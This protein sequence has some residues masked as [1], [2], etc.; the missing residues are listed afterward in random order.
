MRENFVISK[1]ENIFHN[2][3]LEVFDKTLINVV[4]NAILTFW[5]Q[6]ISIA[7][8]AINDFEELRQE[9]LV[10]NLNFFTTQMKQENNS[11]ITI[12][13]NDNFAQEFLGLALESRKENFKLNELTPLEI[14]ILNS[15]CEFLYK[16]LSEILIPLE[17]I[18]KTQENFDN[19]KYI[20]ILYEILPKKADNV[21][22]LMLSV[23]KNRLKFPPIQK[24][25]AFLDTDFSTSSTNV[26][27]KVG[28][29]K[30]S[31]QDLKN[32]ETED[33]VL[34]ENSD[35]AIATLISGEYQKRFSL[36]V[37]P[38]LIVDL[39]EDFGENFEEEAKNNF[40][41][42]NYEVSMEKNLWDDIEVEIGAEFEKV[43]MSI[44]ELKQITQG[45]I[46]DLGSIFE[47][48]ISLFVEN[49][50]V[51]T[52]ELMIINDRYAVK[53]NKILSS[54]KAQN[55]QTAP[56]EEKKAPAQNIQKPAPQA[57]RGPQA[58]PR[59]AQ[60]AQAKPNP[61]PQV[62]QDQKEDFDY[63]DFEK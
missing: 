40:E 48:E 51:A 41:K 58:A 50:K 35:P 25:Q 49:K 55:I 44:G 19:K 36:K 56:K 34:L 53:L 15:F 17:E 24:T 32:L 38:S 14:K 59:G 57:P 18:K 28:T 10:E 61:Q 37:N 2:V 6:D 3:N 26:K 4:K 29:S 47:S 21:A 52:G 8:R 5:E 9:A 63:S 62:S 7:T 54:S 43:K 16:K 20:N 42:T 31:L 27:I 39:G 23:P 60:Q 1:S 11:P 13:I 33:I 46:V 45:Q 30:I 12:R 22:S